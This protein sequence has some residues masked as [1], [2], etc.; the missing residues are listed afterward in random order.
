[1]LAV[2]FTGPYRMDIGT[3][4][5]GQEVRHLPFCSHCDLYVPPLQHCD[6]GA[7]ISVQSLPSVRS[8]EAG[9]CIVLPPSL[10]RMEQSA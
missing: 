2:G 4:K 7:T 1:M 10:Y 9:V 6:A 5:L 8:A 3:R